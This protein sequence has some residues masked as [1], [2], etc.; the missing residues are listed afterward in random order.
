MAVTR[1]TPSHGRVAV[2]RPAGVPMLS[3][4]GER[5][6]RARLL[7]RVQRVSLCLSMRSA[8]T[9]FYPP[10]TRRTTM[11]IPQL[12]WYN[13]EERREWGWSLLHLRHREAWRRP[14]APLA[15][16]TVRVLRRLAANVRRPAAISRTAVEHSSAVIRRLPEREADWSRPPDRTSGRPPQRDR[17]KRPRFTTIGTSNIWR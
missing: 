1:R 12:T 7:R 15:N 9:V 13:R 14:R 6:P 8:S 3:V 16:S 17:L 2:Q 4:P 5:S 10:T 11:I